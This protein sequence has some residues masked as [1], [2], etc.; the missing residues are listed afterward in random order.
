MG[1][2]LGLDVRVEHEGAV[3]ALTDGERLRTVLLNVLGNARE[4]AAQR[5]ARDGPP[6]RGLRT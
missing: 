6:G 5:R 1:S 3:T 4:A 2:A